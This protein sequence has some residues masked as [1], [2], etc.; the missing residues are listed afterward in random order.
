MTINPTSG[1]P[2]NPVSQTTGPSTTTNS[3]QGASNLSDPSLVTQQFSSPA[4]PAIGIPFPTDPTD[5]SLMGY[6][7]DLSGPR[8]AFQELLYNVYGTDNLR[9]QP[10]YAA[11]LIQAFGA[12]T[13]AS[14]VSGLSLQIQN[15]QNNYNQQV[16]NFNNETS[17][18]NGTIPNAQTQ[19]NTINQAITDYNNATAEYAT[20]T[21]VYNDATN[22]YNQATEDF[23]NGIIT[24][25]EYDAA[26]AV[27]DLATAAYTV[28]TNAYNQATAT[29][30][31]AVDNYNTFAQ[32]ENTTI[33]NYNTQINDFNGQVDAYNNEID[34]INTAGAAYGMPPIPH[35]PHMATIPDL[36]LVSA[37]SPTTVPN[38]SAAPLAN[39]VDL[40]SSIDFLSGVSSTLN[41]S[42]QQQFATLAGQ[43]NIYNEATEVQNLS[44]N[45]KTIVLPA[46][47]IN[48]LPAQFNAADIVSAAASSINTIGALGSPGFERIMAQGIFN[49]LVSFL[50][51]PLKQRLPQALNDVNYQLIGNLTLLATIPAV[52]FI[53]ERI[54]ALGG[55]SLTG[56]IGLY[57]AQAE[58]IREVA[59]SPALEQAIRQ[60]LKNDAEAANLSYGEIA[61]VSRGLAAALKLSLL[62]QTVSGLGLTLELPGLYGQLLANA[63]EVLPKSVIETVNQGPTTLTPL[64]DVVS[65]LFL[66]KETVNLLSPLIPNAETAA[67][68]L[69]SIL[70]KANLKSNEELTAL[71]QAQVG[72]LGISPSNT[73]AVTAGIIRFLNAEAANPLLDTSF[74]PAFVPQGNT[75]VTSQ[76]IANVLAQQ[77]A[78]LREFRD[79]LAVRLVELGIIAADA[80]QIAEELAL[81]TA[82]A[83][84]QPTSPLETTSLKTVLTPVE[85][86]QQLTERIIAKT[87][88]DLGLAKAQELANAVVY[89]LLGSSARATDQAEQK[90]P[91]SIL[92]LVKDQ[93]DRLKKIN[94]E[95]LTEEVY[96]H[97]LA[98]IQLPPEAVVYLNAIIR[99]AENFHSG[100]FGGP[101]ASKP[102]A[103]S[104]RVGGV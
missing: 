6:L 19:I 82:K 38:I 68:E 72:K 64:N 87:Q 22:V 77:P 21:Q 40:T 70:A 39:P 34:Q 53:G 25:A 42:K 24:Q 102:P 7:K 97:F 74:I 20:A 37:S 12:N 69:I 47:F 1:Q 41:V 103:D 28:A 54:L 59:A 79:S 48:D 104:M 29:F 67:S 99:P 84:P 57:A 90:N 73:N 50:S 4:S 65:R 81:A 76:A 14:A 61:A 49:R 75:P 58:K 71:L 100:I 5:Q 56:K 15:A 96:D 52:K 88:A 86:A 44:R 80:K 45:G 27:Y 10:F 60:F 11:L 95:K 46:A 78:T 101:Q 32:N 3:P 51:R 92:N 91:L 9:S 36:P 16:E 31:A 62:G 8:L 98:T 30:Q 83:A 33:D 63:P 23:N 18:F 94:D 85:L 43:L 89:S 2:T 26:T 66:Q 17:T 13:G 55:G 93:T 35:E